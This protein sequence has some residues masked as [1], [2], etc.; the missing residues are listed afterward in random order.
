MFSP[1]PIRI[2][3]P[4]TDAALDHLVDGL[5]REPAVFA[6]D[7]GEGQ[8]PY[9][10]R[11]TNLWRRVRR[12]LRAPEG[13]SRMLHLRGIARELCIWP[14]SNSLEASLLVWEQTRLHYPER[15]RR[16]LRLRL[17]YYV[18]LLQGNRFPRAT[19]TRNPRQDDAAF[20]P[21]PTRA[22]A[23]T[24]L[25]QALDLF[26]LRRC[27]EDLEPH[28]AHPGCIYGEMGMCLRPCQAAVNGNTYRAEADA[29]L[30]FLESRGESL[31]ASLERDRETASEALDFETA[32]KLHKRIGRLSGC[33]PGTSLPRLLSRL[34]GVAVATGQQPGEAQLWVVRAGH[35]QAPVTIHS[36]SLEA[37]TLQASLQPAQGLAREHSPEIRQELLALLVKWRH[38]SWCDGEW[39]ELAREEPL[40]VRRLRNAIRRVARQSAD[41]AEAEP[42]RTAVPEADKE[43]DAEA[44]DL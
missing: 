10:A 35:L 26:Q 37:G 19:L 18:A 31:R 36:A 1:T 27:E 5:P 29:F 7:V 34:D 6:V 28:P 22:E 40:S 12:L 20:G 21:F 13:Q 4:A 44:R 41:T 3:L 43:T 42:T 9:V 24:F 16:V 38:S 39:L 14:T 23:E 2:P 11:T 25:N 15:Y 33:F 30:Q 8:Q 32:A 17:P